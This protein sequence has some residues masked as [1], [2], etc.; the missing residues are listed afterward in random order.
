[1]SRGRP[2]YLHLQFAL[3]EAH[4]R[5]DAEECSVYSLKEIWSFTI[6]CL[7]ALH[8]SPDFNEIRY[9]RYTSSNVE[10]TRVSLKSVQ[11]K[12]YFT[13]GPVRF[14]VPISC[15]SHPISTR[16]STW[17][18]YALLLSRHEVRSDLSSGE[19]IFLWSHKL[20]LPY[21]LH[22]CPISTKFST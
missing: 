3:L 16:F 13:Y 14:L 7:Y 15:I 1:M 5:R 4:G 11:W 21:S 18:L 19:Y 9:T 17:R 20:F 2:W 12:P 6:F 22:F 10:Q 8:F